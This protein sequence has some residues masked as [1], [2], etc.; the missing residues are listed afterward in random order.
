MAILAMHTLI[1]PIQL[2]QMDILALH[3]PRC[4]YLVLFAAFDMGVSGGISFAD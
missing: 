1:L 4:T 2:A 3:S